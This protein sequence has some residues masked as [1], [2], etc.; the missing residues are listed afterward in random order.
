MAR[1]MTGLADAVLGIVMIR[2]SLRS[3]IPDD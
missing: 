1:A 2:L 3:A